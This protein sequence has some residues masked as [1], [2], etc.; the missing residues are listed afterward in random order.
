MTDLHFLIK[1][2]SPNEKRYVVIYINRF[3]SVKTNYTTLYQ[4]IEKQEF[5]DEIELTKK[6][7]KESFIKHLSVTKHY[8]FELILNAMQ[9]YYDEHFMDWK[10]KK[11]VAQI[12]VLTSKGL[13]NAAHKLILKTKKECWQYENYV[14]L[15]EVLGHERWLFG[16]KRI[17]ADCPKFGKNIC[18]EELKVIEIIH[19]LT[20]YKKIWHTLNYYELTQQNSTKNEYHKLL[21]DTININDI[22][23]PLENSFLLKAQYHSTLAHYYLLTDDVKNQFLQNKKVVEIREEQL[24]AQPESPIDL[25]ATYYNFMLACYNNKQWADLK[26]YLEKIQ[27]IDTKSI[28]KKIKLFHDYYYCALLYY[29]GTEDYSNS[30]FLID[31]I[32]TG[33]E[34]YKDKIREDFFVWLCQCSGLICFYNKKYKE[35]FFWWQKIILSDKTKVELKKRCAIEFYLLMLSVE[36]ENYDVLD[37]QIKQ[38]EKKLKQ[39]QLLEESEK[40]LLKFF[41]TI[42]K[43]GTPIKS[44]FNSIFESLNLLIIEKK[45]HI[46][47]EFLL[48]WLEN[49]AK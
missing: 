39:H 29:L 31:K 7:R 23:V 42:Y 38:T 12:F 46:I 47:D 10:L 26:I 45:S 34:T 40:Q 30:Y 15:L 36:E 41:K 14:I 24:L 49:R 35:A 22:T 43:N 21:K 11:Q 13:D 18:D 32:K 8:L 20:V 44:Q 17:E 33:L 3:S 4:C 37:Y 16:N 9:E 19:Q 5:Y 2:L 25:F 28:E 27:Q 6:L 1:S 48:K